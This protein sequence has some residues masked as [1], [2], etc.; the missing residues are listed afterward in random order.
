MEFAPYG[1]FFMQKDIIQSH[2]DEKLARTYFRQLIAGME[3]L[4]SM[5]AFHLDL[6]LGNLLIGSDYSLKIADFDSAMIGKEAELRTWGTKNYRPLELRS[7]Y[8]RYPDRVD[9][10]SAGIILF[11]LRTGVY[12]YVED[13][14]QNQHLMQEVLGSNPQKFWELLQGSSL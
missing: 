9:I 1:D 2:K 5:E 10:Y 3:Y 13:M 12:P 11:L 7:G 14:N 4:H 8:C 6:K